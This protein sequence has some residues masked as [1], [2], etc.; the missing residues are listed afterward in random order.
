[1]NY[2]KRPTPESVEM[3]RRQ[4][5]RI[6]YLFLAKINVSALTAAFE[7]VAKSLEILEPNIGKMTRDENVVRELLE[8]PKKLAAFA[9]LYNAATPRTKLS[10]DKGAFERHM[11]WHIDT[12]YANLYA[13]EDLQYLSLGHGSGRER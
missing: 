11:N 3:L 13:G 2:F 1:M 9:T 6:R 10:N 4:F 5:Q 8:F 7:A 12:M